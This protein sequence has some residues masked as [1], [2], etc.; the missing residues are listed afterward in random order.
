MRC[1]GTKCPVLTAFLGAKA[2][3]GIA[4][5]RKEVSKEGSKEVRKEGSMS[6]KKLETTIREKGK[7]IRDKG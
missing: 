3:L 6:T 2:P 4:S 7:G 1:H 5:L